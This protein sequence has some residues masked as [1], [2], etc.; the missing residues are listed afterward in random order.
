[1][2]L[3]PIPLEHVEES[4]PGTLHW[5]LSGDFDSVAV[6]GWKNGHI[7]FGFSRL[8]PLVDKLGIL[9]Y[10][11]FRLWADLAKQVYREEEE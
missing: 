7:Y 3:I 5:A 8:S 10:A 1:M 9:E 11:R 4:V 6:L 2:S